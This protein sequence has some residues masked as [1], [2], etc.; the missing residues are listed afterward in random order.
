MSLS[1]L[2]VF[3]HGSLPSYPGIS[4][5]RKAEIGE[6]WGCYSKNGGKIN[7]DIGL[8]EGKIVSFRGGTVDLSVTQLPKETQ[9]P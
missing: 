1:C 3:A 2:R 4:R 7:K 9:M 5:E 8:W 6:I